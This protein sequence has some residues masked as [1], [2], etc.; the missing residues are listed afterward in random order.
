MLKQLYANALLWLMRPALD[1]FEEQM[2]LH[3]RAKAQ[4]ACFDGIVGPGSRNGMIA[5]ALRSA[6]GLIRK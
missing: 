4:E 2:R 3:R 6:Y 1:E 5:T